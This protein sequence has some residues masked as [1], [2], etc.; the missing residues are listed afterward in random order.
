M[1]S[2][3]VLILVS[4]L[5]FYPLRVVGASPSFQEPEQEGRVEITSP[6]QG[7]TVRG[8]VPITGTA[9]VPDFNNYALEFGF[10]PNVDD[11]WF[12]VQEPV[13]QQVQDGTLGQWDTTI[14]A[15]GNYQLRLRALRNDG[16]FDEVTVT[17]IAVSNA[18]PTVLPTIAPSLTPTATVGIATPG[19]SPTPLIQQ[20]PTRTP[21]P[22]ATPGGPVL[23]PTPNPNAALTR[24]QTRSA[25]CR[26]A[27]IT[28]FF[29]V[30][31][32]IY[33]L[34]RRYARADIRR[35]WRDLRRARS[36][37]SGRGQS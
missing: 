37:R 27:V 11:Q 35:M 18:V 32:G 34:L 31:L 14:I 17:G 36:E 33:S 21:R 3:S 26:G 22:T 4:L 2:R 28:G 23:T 1:N 12:P 16:T 19:P 5:S 29:F 10:D 13:A 8:L 9:F 15:D 7:D 20:P 6:R 24:Q 30:M 25:V